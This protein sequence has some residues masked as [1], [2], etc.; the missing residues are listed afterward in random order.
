MKIAILTPTF[1]PF[2]GIDRLVEQEAGEYSKK[3]GKATIFCFRAEMKSKYADIIELGMPANPFFERLYRLF[4]FLDIFKIGKYAKKLKD[5]DIVVSHL[6]PMNILA[7]KAKRLYNKKY[8]YYNAGIAYPHLFRG[9]F[10]KLYMQLFNF[11]S[12]STIKGADEAI[13]ISKFLRDE[14]NRET[15]I[16]S[17]VK[18]VEVDKKRFHKGIKSD[19]IRKKYKLDK[20]PVLL[21]VGRISPHKGVHLL[22]KVFGELKKEIPEASLVIVGKHTF[23]SY[24]RH[25]RKMADGSVIFAGF[26]DDTEIPYYYAAADVYVTCS[27]W[28]GFDI[29]IAEA[30]AVGKPSVAFDIGSHKEVLKKGVLVK[31]NDLEAFK[32]AVVKLLKMK[33]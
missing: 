1:S 17:K 23:P 19:V 8:I 29:P 16:D 12:N 14:L 13:S 20:K 5:Y 26:V 9:F 21:Y 22:I 31:E 15:G 24:S 30:A 2:S 7:R 11:F 28:E 25:L 18:Y 27:L 3:G 6:Y 32:D 33:K 4:F 10:E